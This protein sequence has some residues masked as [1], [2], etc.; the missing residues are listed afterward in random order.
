MNLEIIANTDKPTTS[1]LNWML[2]IDTSDSPFEVESFLPRTIWIVQDHAIVAKGCVA[3]LSSSLSSP[4]ENGASVSVT[5]TN[6][7]R[8]SSVDF[9][10]GFDTRGQLRQGLAD[11][12]A[13]MDVACAPIKPAF[14]TRPVVSPNTAQ[15]EESWWKGKSFIY[16][17]VGVVLVGEPSEQHGEWNKPQEL[18]VRKFPIAT[19]DV[20]AATEAVH[21]QERK[22][23][24]PAGLDVSLAA[25][26]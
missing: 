6:D 12:A 26:A 4:V 15:I 21:E 14:A 3:A 24:K 13:E 23:P 11:I 5:F 17:M 20:P 10:L 1:A 25:T 7:N 22:T 19:L 2:A 16:Q 9:T 18:V 8:V